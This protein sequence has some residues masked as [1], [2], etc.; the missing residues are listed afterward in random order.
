MAQ[1]RTPPTPPVEGA[2]G[3]PPIVR[4]AALALVEF[5]SIAVGI[6]AADLMV[7][8]APIALLKAGTVHPGH[9]LVLIGGQVAPVTE[10]H[11]VGVAA[12]GELLIDEVL[13]PEVHPQVHDAALGTRQPLEREALGILETRTVASLLR[14]ADAGVKGA[15]VRVAEI[16]LADDLGGR[17]FV[18]FD[19]DV[20]DVEA[21]LAIGAA[22]V[23]PDRLLRCS[24]LPRLDGTLRGALNAGTGFTPCAPIEPDGAELSGA[25]DLTAASPAPQRGTH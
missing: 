4:H 1:P 21:A 24:I 7:K 23:R 25:E 14:A 10:S 9:Y 12:G 6:H 8:R 13:L 2:T 15:Q 11:S 20:A 19:G 5:D 3:G 18:L 16:R 17:A 22:R